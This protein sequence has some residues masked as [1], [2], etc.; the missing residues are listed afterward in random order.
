MKTAQYV[1]VAYQL[2]LSVASAV[3]SWVWREHAGVRRPHLA[4]DDPVQGNWQSP[5]TYIVLLSITFWILYGY[6]VPI[7]LFV[8][9][10]LVKF[11]QAFVFINND[12]VLKTNTEWRQQQKLEPEHLPQH[13]Q[14]QHQQYQHR[15]RHLHHHQQ[16]RV[17]RAAGQ[18]GLDEQSIQGPR[19]HPH[20]H[21]HNPPAVMGPSA[22]HGG[23]GGG[24][25]GGDGG[26]GGGGG[27][28]G[29]DGSTHAF[30]RS[31]AVNEDL[32]R[33]VMV[34]SDKTGTLT[35]NDMR[36]RCCALGEERYGSLD[37]RL[38][39]RPELQGM[40]A[41]VAFDARLPQGPS[42]DEVALLEAARQL[43]FELAARRGDQVELKLAL[44]PSP[45]PPPALPPAAQRGDGTGTDAPGPDEESLPPVAVVVRY[46]I[47]NVL[48]FTSARKRMSVV[49]E[50]PD[51]SLAVHTKGADSVV[52]PRLA[53]AAAAGG[54]GSDS[55]DI[56]VAAA[57]ENLHY[58]ATLGLRTLVL[59]ARPL[60]DRKWYDNWDARYQE[61]AAAVH[62]DPRVRAAALDSLAEEIE[63]EMQ[64]VGVAA[65]EDQLQDGVPEAVA[66]LLAAGVRVWMITGDK[67]ETAVNIARAA[68]LVTQPHDSQLLV[69][70]EHEEQAGEAHVPYT[71]DTATTTELVVDG[72]TLDMVL[73]RRPLAARL[74][75]L[76]A[77]CA[78]V[79]VCRASPAQKAALVQLMR[80]YR[81]RLAAARR[82]R[83]W[84]WLT[85]G[86]SG[87]GAAPP[88]LPPLQRLL[89]RWWGSCCTADRRARN[90]D[91]RGFCGNDGDGD[92]EEVEKEEVGGSAAADGAGGVV[93]GRGC[94]DPRDREGV[95]L[96]IGDGA[97]DVAM[98]QATDVGVG[99]MGKEGRQAVNNS[100]VAV[101]LF[102]HL[103]PLLLVHGQLCSE[104][105]S[106]L[107]TYSFYK[108]LAYWGVLLMFQFYCG[109]SGQALIDDI[110]GSFYNVVFTA[111]PI[112]VVALQ[113]S[114]APDPSVTLMQHPELYN[115][116]PPLTPMRFWLE[117][118]M[119]PLF[120]SAACF[121]IPMYS[122]TPYGTQ[123]AH[124]LWVV[125]KASYMAV[126]VAVTAELMLTTRA[127]TRLLV[128][129]CALSVVVAFPFLLLVW[130]LELAAGYLDEATVGA[131]DLLFKS[132]YFWTSLVAV[133]ALTAGSREK[134]IADAMAA[135]PKRIAEYR[136]SRKLDW[137]EVSALDRLLL[138]PGQIREKYI[139][140]RLTRQNQ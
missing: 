137:S 34:F 48:E 12:P 112:L 19:G 31:S 69:L 70:R 107:I 133:V 61:A 17:H 13:Q 117:G 115:A 81:R 106:R 6:L 126:V 75:A 24:G 23:G 1:F 118:I 21:H 125:G 29:A 7:S 62:T 49:V 72:R 4:L 138:T 66:T 60:P 130:R 25:G 55:E 37:V 109:F 102:R 86:A 68:R 80:D 79:V 63:R 64:L 78:S 67:L 3:V 14:H 30:A 38:E 134:E 131:A 73:D 98:I 116:H 40:E 83:R 44:P 84:H 15:H 101:P 9:M 127:W 58:F 104:R 93:G 27:A 56:R 135:M 111:F 10:E 89:Q 119:L 8:T 43:G 54:S 16:Q 128:V 96:A 114:H 35:R 88:P 52:L 18:Q 26:G 140:R 53:A 11:W 103:V 129:V 97:N 71:V 85:G 124:V 113:E 36:F 121:F 76:C 100:D 120:H 22:M 74:A 45:A 139:R 90:D 46:R 77:S 105:L 108:N 39:E 82:R 2:L 87:G 42:P 123:P 132:P 51:G 59:A 99:V 92:D 122:A 20:Q 110:S 47:L 57:T 91:Q 95:L 28:N 33:V 5:V 94:T 32:G 65:I 50:A 41:V 136:A